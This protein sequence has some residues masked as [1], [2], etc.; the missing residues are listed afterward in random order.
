MI[1]T[2]S[3]QGVRGAGVG[4]RS[5]AGIIRACTSWPT[6]PRQALESQRENPEGWRAGG[7][8]FAFGAGPES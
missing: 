5:G 7:K 2:F 6:H 1:E 4:L 8:R 3:G